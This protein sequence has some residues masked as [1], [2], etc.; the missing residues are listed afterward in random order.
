MLMIALSLAISLIPT[1]SF[2][3]LTQSGSG[4]NQTSQSSRVQ[5]EKKEPA[6]PMVL[7]LPS[8]VTVEPVALP[9]G[10]NAW[11]VQI[12]SRGGFAGKGR[13]DLTLT[14]EGNLIWNGPDGSCSRKLSDETMNALA[15]IV[16][17][18]DAP[19]SSTERSPNLCADCYVTGI[20]LQYRAGSG[21]RAF[22]AIWDDPSQAKVSG[23]MIAVYEALMAQEG[24][25]L[26]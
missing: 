21:V 12:V 2:V 11:A 25:K 23:N 6:Y 19:P 24:C 9:P 7:N 3:P 26:Q 1:Q 16:F 17:A 5:K 18:V 4:S 14:S 10:E 15:K 8:T 20:I 13:G 22:S